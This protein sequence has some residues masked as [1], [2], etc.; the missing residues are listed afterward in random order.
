MKFDFKNVTVYIDKSE[1]ILIVPC[2]IW[3]AHNITAEISNI[4]ELKHPYTL[5]QLQFAL[6]EGLQLCYSQNVD[7]DFPKVTSL[8]KYLNVKGY[9]KAIKNKKVVSLFWNKEDGYQ[10]TPT[11]YA[12]KKGF[13][14]QEENTIILGAKPASL[15][16]AEA[17]VKA[18]T[19]SK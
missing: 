13:V 3:P 6:E 17:V 4:V 15:G 5:E 19:L 18:I 9:K 14:H 10:V 12:D 11:T 16:I 1:D 8:E 2:G 7:S